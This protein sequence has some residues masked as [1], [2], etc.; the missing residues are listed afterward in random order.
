LRDY[1]VS[2]PESDRTELLS[3]IVEQ[4]ERLNRFIANLLDMTRIE[5]GAMEPNLSLHYLGDIVGAA[6]HRAVKILAHHKL[7]VAVAAGLPMLRLDA[8][9]FE[10]VLFNLLDNAAKY[11][12]QG[13]EI[14]LEA[15]VE[16]GHVVLEISDHGPGIPDIDLERVFDTFYR[17]RKGDHVQAGTGLGLSI[18]RGF[19][20]AMGGTIRAGNRAEGSGARFTITIPLPLQ[21]IDRNS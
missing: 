11:A 3:T 17:V 21:E 7:Q 4:S 8:V 20:E 15:H 6:L 2:L 19:T 13:S 12:P 1:S 16:R 18:A 14:A 10:Q 5:S 9:L